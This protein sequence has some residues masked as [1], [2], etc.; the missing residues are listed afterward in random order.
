MEAYVARD[1]PRA[2][3]RLVLRIGETVEQLADHPGIGRAGRVEG[4]RELVVTGTPYLVA[5]RVR[6][7]YVQILRVL[8]HAQKWPE[9]M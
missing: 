3:V 4:T 6:G 7:G 1:D 2:A 5:Y 9:H 8:H